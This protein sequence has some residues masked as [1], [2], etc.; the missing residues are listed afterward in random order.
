MQSSVYRDLTADE[1]SAIIQSALCTTV[2]SSEHLS[3]GMFNTT[4]KVETADCG[5]VVLRTGPVNRH[6]LM[7]FE[8]DLMASE[9]EVYALCR[10]RGI[11]VSEVLACDTSK[12]VVDRDF[13]IVRTLDAYPVLRIEK[14]ASAEDFARICREIGEAA[15]AFHAVE[16]PRFGRIAEVRRGG[17]FDRWSACMLTEFERWESVAAPTRLFS[18]EEHRAARTVLTECAPILDEITHPRLTHCDLWFGNIL[19]TKEEH[20]RFAA[21]IDADR[22]MWGDVQIDFSSIPWTKESPAFWE[23][24]GSA[25]PMDDHTKIRRHIYTMMWSLFDTY[26]WLH[27]YN[28]PESAAYT[29]NKTLIQIRALHDDYGIGTGI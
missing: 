20:P 25:L 8:H 29:K 18:S 11:P 10:A 22:A 12:T 6:L 15:R 19:V 21:I 14:T 16:G 28:N 9:D 4:Y 27:E 26:V 5:S 17:G 1:L 23:G 13:M 3:G 24:Y 2:L 7:P